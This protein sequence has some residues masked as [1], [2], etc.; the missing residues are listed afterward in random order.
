MAERRFFMKYAIVTDSSCDLKSLPSSHNNTIYLQAPLSLRIGN[1]EFID[2][3]NLDIENFMNEMQ[4]STEAT[5]SAAPSPQS[6]IDAFEQADI[7]FAITISSKLSG[8]WQSLISAK[9]M[10]LE[11]HP[12]K[13][14]F[15]ID[16]KMAGSG[17]AILA[18]KLAEYIDENLSYEEICTR[19]TEYHKH[20]GLLF[21]LESIENLVKN[22]RVNKIIGNIIGK[23]GIKLLAGASKE[24]TIDI[25]H[26]C[27]GRN[28]IYDRLIKS[29]LN[30]GYNGGKVVISHCFNDESANYVAGQLRQQFP[31]VNI[32]I[33]PTGGLCSYYAEKHGILVSYEK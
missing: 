5:G 4:E 9:D 24:G 31:T 23:L 32:K 16:S 14:I 7:I 15:A 26:K 20:I 18:L 10:Y 13:K 8:S 12:D 29:M 27:R 11:D 33:I 1:R 30:N 2:D 17:L 3:E 6:W 21:V 28:N 19:I 25:V 22:G